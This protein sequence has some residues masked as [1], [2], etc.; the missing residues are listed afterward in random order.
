[1]AVVQ[2]PQ[3]LHLLLNFD[4][5]QQNSQISSQIDEGE[6]EERTP[7]SMSDESHGSSN[8]EG[9][10]LSSEGIRGSKQI[11]GNRIQSSISLLS[12]RFPF[13][14]VVGFG[15]SGFLNSTFRVIGNAA[16]SAAT[17]WMQDFRSPGG[18]DDV[19]N[20]APMPPT[21]RS[22]SPIKDLASTSSVSAAAVTEDDTMAAEA[23]QDVDTGKRLGGI[24][25]T[26]DPPV[27]VSTQP[28]D[29]GLRA[30]KTPSQNAMQELVVETSARGQG[31][32]GNEWNA[33]VNVKNPSAIGRPLLRDRG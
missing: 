13:S 8:V 30:D 18:S 9:S 28:I 29:D 3:S 5:L 14:G 12:K 26:P 33:T 25:P 27:L 6:S 32:N 1:M 10:Q 17:S 19:G 20:V 23:L 24:S 21:L 16:Y 4:L 11:L 7:A 22:A 15:S 31:Q 2:Q